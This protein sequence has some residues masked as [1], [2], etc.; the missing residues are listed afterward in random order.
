MKQTI[1]VRRE[2]LLGVL[3]LAV[4][5]SGCANRKAVSQDTNVSSIK[6]MILIGDDQLI[7]IDP[8]L[9]TE[10]NKHIFWQVK[11]SEV[12]NLPDSLHHYYKTMDDAKSVD[13][14]T[15]LLA[16]SSGGGVV[17]IDR[18]R[19]EALFYTI[20]PNAHSIEYLPD[21][22]IAVALS[23][24]P[25]GNSLNIYDLDQPDVILYSDSLYSGHGATWD[26]DR[27]LLYALGYDELR[28]YSLVNWNSDK[29]E[30]KLE[31]TWQTPETGGHDLFA[32]DP[33]KL[34]ISTSNKV[35]EFDIT[36]EQFSPFLPIA[37]T[38]HVKSVYFDEDTR[39]LVYTKGEISWWTHQI[40]FQN[41]DKTI[42]VPEIKLYKV[43]VIK[44]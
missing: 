23:T 28:A 39:E 36:G 37:D 30:L 40:H 29:P 7:I 27:E 8:N 35:W 34:L 44:K 11:I 2:S 21:N 42:K 22:K 41:P 17:L 14:D 9:S 6:E 33:D 12:K 25:N 31:Q 15:K 26:K 20:A 13:N 4:L 24:N 10:D 38:A 3:I 1:K 5:I 19:K 16:S 43:R 32:S 18:K